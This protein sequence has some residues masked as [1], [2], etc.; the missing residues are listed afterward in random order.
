MKLRL[1]GGPDSVGKIVLN[2]RNGKPVSAKESRKSV[3]YLKSANE[4]KGE[5]R[6]VTRRGDKNKKNDPT[7]TTTTTTTTTM[8]RESKP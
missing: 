8:L 1:D 7:T 5:S 6:E 2:S 3:S 4:K